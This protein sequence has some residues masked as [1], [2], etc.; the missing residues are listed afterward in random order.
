M[1]AGGE[2]FKPQQM[3]LALKHVG[4]GVTAYIVGKTKKGSSY[5]FMVTSALLEKQIGKQVSLCA[6]W[7]AGEPVCIDEHSL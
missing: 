1:L 5:T 2:T 3:F 4:T 6:D 7:K